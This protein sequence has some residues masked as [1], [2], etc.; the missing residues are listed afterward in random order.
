MEVMMNKYWW[1]SGSSVR[2]G[3]NWIKWSGLCM[4]KC[5]G[6]LAF[7]DL[8]GYN[9]ALM[10]KHV[11][12]FV[13]SP[14]SMVSRNNIP[15]RSRLSSKG[16]HNPV[17]CLMCTSAVEDLRQLFFQCPFALAYWSSYGAVYILSTE[18]SAPGWLLFKLDLCP[19]KEA[20]LIATILWGIWFFRNKE[21]RENKVVTADVAMSW[22]AKTISDWKEARDK[23]PAQLVILG[24]TICKRMVSS[25]FE[26]E[27]LTIFE[28]LQWLIYMSLD[29]VVIESDSFLSIKALRNS[30]ETCRR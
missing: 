1:Q 3:I 15:V 12:N 20:L 7:R 29:K 30:Q 10:A 11:W 5:H 24:K 2:K 19:T 21:V 9:I 22:S 28:G 14:Q 26:A 23:R 13:Y 4:F 25:V 27:A 16:V 18:D 17:D 8:Y 6:G